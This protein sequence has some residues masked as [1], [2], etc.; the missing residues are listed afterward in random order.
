[1]K[2]E[3]AAAA[4]EFT[5]TLVGNR[6]LNDAE[7]D[8][9]FDAGCDDALVGWQFERVFV[10]FDREAPTLREAVLSAIENVRTAGFRVAK[11]EVD[12]AALAADVNSAL[13]FQA[14]RERDPQFMNA[15][16]EASSAPTAAA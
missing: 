16:I 9:L 4:H 14:R 12:D 10:D 15:V 3:T 8:A 6:P 2:I 7:V 11:V 13:D 1:M 5:L